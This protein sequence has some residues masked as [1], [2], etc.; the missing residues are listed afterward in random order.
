MVS[1]SI[2][3][4]YKGIAMLENMM[5]SILNHFSFLNF[6]YALF[7]FVDSIDEIKNSNILSFHVNT[8]IIYN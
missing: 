5:Y 3:H 8:P 1:L 7:R 4:K 6:K 2:N